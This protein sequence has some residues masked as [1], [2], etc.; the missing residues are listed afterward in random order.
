M[1]MPGKWDYRSDKDFQTN[2]GGNGKPRMTD[3]TITPQMEEQFKKALEL[4]KLAWEK[5]HD[6][7]VKM[8]E[9]MKRMEP[10]RIDGL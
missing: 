10:N 5:E 8:N 6:H 3:R 1:G 7:N 9:A 2:H 4:Q